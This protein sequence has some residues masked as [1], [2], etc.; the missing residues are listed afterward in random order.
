LENKRGNTEI[1]AGGVHLLETHRTVS[2]NDAVGREVCVSRRIRTNTP[3]QALVTLNDS[4]YLDLSRQLAYRMKKKAGA[5][6]K[7]AISI[8]Y[9]TLLFKP[10]A[11]AKL[12]ALTALYSNAYNKFKRDPESACEMIGEDNE[13][14]NPETAALVAVAN[15][16][17]NLDEV[18]TKN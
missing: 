8:G 7:A 18:V 9:E 6:A 14:N 5:D 13:H 15:A 11:P 4:A 3:L 16:L 2:F 10:I 17:L 12:N 1:P